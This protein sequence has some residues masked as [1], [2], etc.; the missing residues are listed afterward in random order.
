MISQPVPLG[1][2]LCDYVIV[3][4][5]SRKVSLIGMLT[6]LRAKRFPFVA[7]P[8]FAF[9]ALTDGLGDATIDLVG[10]SLSD[11]TDVFTEQRRVS[12]SD[13]LREVH[14]IF[15]ITATFPTA[16]IYQFTVKVDGEWV[17]QRRLRV[18]SEQVNP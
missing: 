14:L 6:K 5:K 16:G 4:E 8:F 13:K 12:F 17:A 15:Q 7:P 2:T 18:V 10:T 3:A 1:L 11:A 9:L